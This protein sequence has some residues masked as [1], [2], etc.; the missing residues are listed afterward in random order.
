MRAHPSALRKVYPVLRFIRAISRLLPDVEKRFTGTISSEDDKEGKIG[1][2]LLAQQW[3][4]LA[5]AV[6]DPTCLYSTSAATPLLKTI[7]KFSA[8]RCISAIPQNVFIYG[9]CFWS[10]L[11][12]H[13]GK[14]GENG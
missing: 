1:K 3:Q 4:Q 13:A 2:F 10:F 7:G 14:K 8:L 6:V 12:L 5:E 9:I 11:I